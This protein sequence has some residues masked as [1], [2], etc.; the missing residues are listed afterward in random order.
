M[1][2]ELVRE[3]MELV[4]EVRSWSVRQGAGQGGE[5]LVRGYC[6]P[7]KFAPVSDFQT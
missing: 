2:V 7:P 5:E 6:I 1:G 4:R 3:V